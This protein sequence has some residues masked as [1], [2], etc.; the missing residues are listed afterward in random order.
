MENA[1]LKA[2]VKAKL[3]AELA[4]WRNGAKKWNVSNQFDESVLES[5]LEN[6]DNYDFSTPVNKGFAVENIDGMNW[7]FMISKFEAPEIDRAWID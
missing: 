1:E 4:A 5:A 7:A 6:I 2:V 3:E